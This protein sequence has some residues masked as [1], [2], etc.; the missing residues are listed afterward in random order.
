VRSALLIAVALGA[1]FAVSAAARGDRVRLD[2]VG[3][4][5]YSPAA[6]AYACVDFALQ[7]D[8]T[9]MRDVSR[10]PDVTRWVQRSRS[11][12]GGHRAIALVTADSRHEDGASLL[13]IAERAYQ[14]TARL[15]RPRT[16]TRALAEAARAGY[17]QPVTERATLTPGTWIP[18][19]GVHLRFT[20]RDHEGDASAYAIGSVRVTCTAPPSPTADIPNSTELLG[21]HRRGATATAFR[22]PNAPSIA[23]SLLEI[24]GGESSGY[25]R[26]RTLIQRLDTSAGESARAAFERAQATLVILETNVVPITAVAHQLDEV[27]HHRPVRVHLDRHDLLD[28]GETHV[29]L[30][31][32]LVRRTNR[33]ADLHQDLQS[34][35]DLRRHEPPPLC[36]AVVHRP[37]PPFVACCPAN[38]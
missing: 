14:H 15:R 10:Q 35:T 36:M 25:V 29:E 32:A 34:G 1:A 7:S 28:V 24:G 26:T 9:G 16:L 3:C 6:D 19:A 17:A 27:E 31:D 21:D 11:A 18:F 2:R 38:F 22:A 33:V 13:F 30:V 37:S 4:H 23:L 8:D 20:T 12:W 5:L